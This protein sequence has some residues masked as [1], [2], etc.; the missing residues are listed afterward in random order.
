M[1]DALQLAQEMYVRYGDAA[2]WK[3]YAGHPM[4]A[5]GA[6]PEAIRSYWRVAADHAMTRVLDACRAD[7]EVHSPSVK[8][9]GGV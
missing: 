5:W 8:D 4:P 2:G 6:L 3:N 7:A 9:T 1:I